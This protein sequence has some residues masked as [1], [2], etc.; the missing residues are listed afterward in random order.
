MHLCFERKMLPSLR[1]RG[2]PASRSA[3]ICCHPRTRN[4]IAFSY[5]ILGCS[6]ARKPVATK[7]SRGHQLVVLAR[8]LLG[9]ELYFPTSYFP[10][11]LHTN[12]TTRRTPYTLLQAQIIAMAHARSTAAPTPSKTLVALTLQRF[13]DVTCPSRFVIPISDSA[14]QTGHWAGRAIQLER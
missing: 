10:T 6:N 9:R 11:P 7:A 12:V 5:Y 3:W 1:R 14:K 8:C 4:D 13:P 2:S